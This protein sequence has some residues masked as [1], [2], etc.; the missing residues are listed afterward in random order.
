[1]QNEFGCDFT[2]SFVLL[3]F[4]NRWVSIKA[5]VAEI[6]AKLVMG[7]PSYDMKC[8]VSRK[9]T[10]EIFQALLGHLTHFIVRALNYKSA[11]IDNVREFS[12]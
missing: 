6:R 9:V 12:P 10:L 1:L 11:S 8:R 2:D 3:F 7:S 4:G 5:W